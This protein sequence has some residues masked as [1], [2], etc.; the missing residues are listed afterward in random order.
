[1]SVDHF[2]DFL[3]LEKGKM[4]FEKFMEYEASNREVN[5]ENPDEDPVCVMLGGPVAHD[6]KIKA[7]ANPNALGGVD[8]V[9]SINPRPSVIT[10]EEIELLRSVGT[11][12]PEDLEAELKA[13]ELSK[14][15]D[16]QL[17]EW[18]DWY[19]YGYNV[20]NIFKHTPVKTEAANTAAPAT[21]AEA[22]SSDELVIDDEEPAPVA[23][24]AKAKTTKKAA[25]PEPEI[26]NP[27]Q[28]D[29]S[30]ELA[31]VGTGEDPDWD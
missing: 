5:L 8:Y 14:K 28:D 26:A 7:K 1:V 3:L 22:T 12:K 20:S 24:P 21:T 25:A 31:S 13:F 27:F 11:P 29:D 23:T 16:P 19:L 4:I 18:N 10:E 9:V 15:S 30:E 17:P 2:P 6:V